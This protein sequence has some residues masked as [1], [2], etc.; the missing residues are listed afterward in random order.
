MSI[1]TSIDKN[2]NKTQGFWQPCTIEPSPSSKVLESLLS[3]K[4]DKSK[5][6]VRKVALTKTH[7][8]K[9]SNYESKPKSSTMISWKK[10]EPFVEECGEVQIWGFR[11]GHLS[12]FEDFFVESEME[13]EKW[14]DAI[15][16]LAIMTD[17]E[18]DY[19]IIQKLGK[20]NYS[21]VNLVHSFD[22]GN[23][24][25]MKSIKIEKGSLECSECII[26]EI[27]ILRQISNEKIIRLH[28]VYE[29]SDEV[30]LVLEKGAWGNLS[31]FLSKFGSVSEFQASRLIK[32]ILGGLEYFQGK[33]IIHRDLK[34]ENILINDENDL[35]QIKI[36]DFGFSTMSSQD[37]T[38]F[39]GSPGY[40]APEILYLMPHTN[41]VDVFSAGIILYIMLSKKFPFNGDS[42]E[43]I[44][45]NNK[46]CLI[47]FKENTWRKMP[48]AVDL[49]QKM[50]EI[51]PDKRICV[52]EAL[53]HPWLYRQNKVNQ[54]SNLGCGEKSE[55]FKDYSTG[56]SFANSN[57][58]EKIQ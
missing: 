12:E 44:M 41:K 1:F 31:Q 42:I 17:P 8:F 24:F 11:L 34:L 18:D 23:L 48:D 4:S 40:I 33:N 5:F 13:L 2:S 10:F 16:G 57:I 37:S 20:G 54:F 39:Y 26:N 38:T 22:T 47:E 56:V 6:K 50:T 49:I 3:F 32:S 55:S 30:H 21:K 52:L 27:S 43:E 35:S 19:T 53:K 29:T 45:R 58:Q 7:L 9:F 28:K 36:C 25:A 51:N 15:S 14:I 46:R